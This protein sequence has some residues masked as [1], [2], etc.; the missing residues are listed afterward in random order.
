MPL[1]KLNDIFLVSWPRFGRRLAH[2]YPSANEFRSL[3]HRERSGWTEQVAQHHELKFLADL[4]RG[5]NALQY[6]AHLVVRP[7][8]RSSAQRFLIDSE[9]AAED[10]FAAAGYGIRLIPFKLKLSATQQ[11]PVIRVYLAKAV[12]F[13]ATQVNGIYSA[14]GCCAWQR[15]YVGAHEANQLRSEG[16]PFPNAIF[17]VLLEILQ[18]GFGLL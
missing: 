14:Q 18:N 9:R 4:H 7:R 15:A 8:R 5:R 17:F 2:A 12:L 3:D 11:M 6:V 16:K 13:S 1:S 10:D